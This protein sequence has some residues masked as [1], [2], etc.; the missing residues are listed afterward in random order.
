MF[1]KHYF[2]KDLQSADL[3]IAMLKGQ[4]HLRRHFYIPITV[5]IMCFVYSYSENGQIPETLS[6]LYERFVLLYVYFNV[7]DAC[8]QEFNTLYDILTT[9]KPLFGKLCKTAYD[10]LR[11][12]K[13]VFD[14]EVLGITDSDLKSLNLDSKQFDGF[15]LL[16]V[17]YFPTKLATMKRFYSF[18]HRAVQELLAAIFV[19]DTGNIVDVL[20]DHFYEDSFLMNMFPFL[21][22]LVS[23][24]VL[25]SLAERLIQIFIGSYSLLLYI[26]HCLFETHD[27]TLCR[28]FGQV[29]S[30]GATIS[31]S[32][33]T[34]LEYRY[35]CYFIG[36]CGIQRL[37]VDIQCLNLS[38]DTSD[39]YAEILYK[40]L[41][42]TL[43][44]IESFHN[45]F[46]HSL[47]HKGTEQLA[48]A[49]SFQNDICSVKLKG[50]IGAKPGCVKILCDSICK[51][52]PKI[53]NLVLPEG[54]FSKDDL[55]RLA[56]S[57]LAYLLKGYT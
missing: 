6:K 34:L 39:L 5:A 13:L 41:Q 52:N 50:Y 45:T 49:L 32:T 20:N 53:I 57:S 40:Y 38:S 42:S 10:M 25:R 46:Y 11:D 4:E 24:E 3:L 12:D 18:I 47:S 29:F 14:E 44:D 27:D 2:D 36:A 16:H 22:G 35:V 17:E 55:E 31:L 56:L 48:K 37:N 23:K 15:G 54:E 43:T 51:H 19:M 1:I 30:K 9:L 26:L 21:F 8:R 28:G 7:P 33:H